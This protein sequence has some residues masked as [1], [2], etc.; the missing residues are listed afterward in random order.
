MASPPV[1]LIDIEPS[2]G[3]TAGSGSRTSAARSFWRLDFVI[4]LVTR[5]LDGRQLFCATIQASPTTNL[6]FAFRKLAMC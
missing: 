1:L 3:D 5:W 6:Q 2:E 4:D